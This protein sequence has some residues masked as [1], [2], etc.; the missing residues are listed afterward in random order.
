G[1]SAFLYGS[2]H[3]TRG[4]LSRFLLTR[5][6]WLVC[7]EIV[8]VSLAWNFNVLGENYL[9]WLQVIWILG[10]SMIVLSGLVWLPRLAIAVIALVLILGHNLLDGVQPAQG[11]ASMLWQV[12]HIQGPLPDFDLFN[13][14]VL[15]PLIP[16]PGVMALGFVLGQIFLGDPKVRVRQL[17]GLGATITVAFFVFRYFQLYGEPNGW[18]VHPTIPATLVD[19]FNVTKYPPSLQYLMMTLGPILLLLGLL[20]HARGRIANIFLTYGRVPFF[21]YVIHLYVIHLCAIALGWALGFAVSDMFVFF[22]YYP[23]DFGISL[24]VVYAL[25]VAIVVALYPLCHWFAGV[26]ARRKDWWLSYL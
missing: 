7:V 22:F 19:F 10:L 13:A 14:F 18:V 12:L 6:I 5:G 11:D 16:W 21:F 17:I 20:D 23:P 26:K 1:V 8:F 4:D 15:Y 25:W 9:L 3:H 24:G 2:H